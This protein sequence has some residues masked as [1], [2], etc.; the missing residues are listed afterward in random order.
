MARR[1][2]SL[3]LLGGCM[4]IVMTAAVYVRAV[5]PPQRTASTA[6]S[7]SSPRAVLDKYCVTCHNERLRT[8]GLTLDTMDIENVG[9]GAEVWEK[10]IRKLRAGAMPPA[11]APRPDQASSESL[12]S[13]LETEIDR[14]AVAAPNPGRTETFHRLNQAEYQNAI[15][16]LLA[17]EIDVAK[18]LPTG[19]ADSEH[20]FDNNANV[21]SISPALLDRYI[22]AARKLSRLAVGT[23]P[24]API[25]EMYRVSAVMVQDDHASEQLPFGSRGGI[26]I[27]HYFPVSGEYSIKITLQKNYVDYIR[28]L[29]EPHPLDIRLDGTRVAQFTVGGKTMKRPAPATYAGNWVGD[30]EW[31]D[32]ALHADAELETRFRADAGLRIVGVSFVGKLTEPEGVRQPIP[33]AFIVPD[34]QD[35]APDGNPAVETV[36]INGPYSVLGPGDT[37]SRRKI[38]GCRP[39]LAADEE[40]C[41]RKILATLA[42]RAY[43]RPVT[44][45]DLRTLL[46]FYTSGRQEAGFEA[47]IQLGLE[48]LLA[49]PDFLFRVEYDPANVA[50]GSSYRLSDLELAS[51]LSFFLWSSIPDDELLDVAGRGKLRDPGELERQARRLLADPRSKALV[52]NFAGQWLRLRDVRSVAPDHRLFYPDFDENLRQSFHRETE[53]FIE[54]QLRDDRSVLDLLRANYSFVNERLARHYGIPNVYG[55]H[56]RRVTFS[57]NEQRGGLLGHGSLLTVTSYPNRTSP[58]LRGKWLLEN[59]LGTPPPPPPPNVPAL[60]D[61]GENGKPAS[62]RERL[63]QHRKNPVCANCHAPMDPLGFALENFDAIGRWRTISDGT[64]IDASGTLPS[65][66]QFVGL[67]G[68]RTLLLSRRE[69]FAGTV[70]EKLLAYALGRTLQYYDFPTVRTIA[71]D[72]ASTDYR[73]SSIILG[74]VKSTPFRLRRSAEGKREPL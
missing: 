66:A 52:D 38:F 73:W 44:E 53:L 68:L 46:D 48:R 43:R 34:N 56:F 27:R 17:M 21:L 70:V 32:Y 8:A 41:A 31:E 35:E 49:S 64:A 30:A 54:S 61:R 9:R 65:G 10:V 28:G 72:A 57:R 74:I 22:S 16:D 18:F 25:G 33:T 26:A 12:A 4:A 1:K 60:R 6:P 51:R 37:P 2:R 62:V 55:N 67:A 36:A 19:D 45:E 5:E 59:V 29:G 23:A 63:E 14:S 24:R 58:V 71:R 47:G 39:T 11:G 15:R 13:Y 42:R 20:G 7:T 40:P 69:Q 50:P 3:I